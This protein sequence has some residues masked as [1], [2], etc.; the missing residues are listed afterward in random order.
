MNLSFRCHNDGKLKIDDKGFK[1]IALEIGDI[2][3]QMLEYFHLRKDT[4]LHIQG[5][6]KDLNC[7]GYIKE[8]VIKSKIAVQFVIQ[9]EKVDLN[10]MYALCRDPEPWDVRIS[11]AQATLPEYEKI[12]TEYQMTIGQKGKELLQDASEELKS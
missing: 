10:L 4:K 12:K 9:S 5:N 3:V 7:E 6:L 2:D 1:T 8:I 11:D